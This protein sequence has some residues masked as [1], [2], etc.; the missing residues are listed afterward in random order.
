M[1]IIE[2]PLNNIQHKGGSMSD[3]MKVIDSEILKAKTAEAL[4]KKV[5]EK[6]KINGWEPEGPVF[7]KGGYWYR[8][9]NQLEKR[10]QF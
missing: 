1:A 3:L 5:K 4:A 7:E 6:M 10:R 8:T 9:M 2:I